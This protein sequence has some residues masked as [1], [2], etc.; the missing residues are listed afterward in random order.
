[1]WD[2]HG[3]WAVAGKEQGKYLNKDSGMS[4]DRSLQEQFPR[5][6]SKC[7][8]PLEPPEFFKDWDWSSAA[9]KGHN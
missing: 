9:G 8:F 4:L 6:V 1:M 3:K 7:A 2:A 5:L